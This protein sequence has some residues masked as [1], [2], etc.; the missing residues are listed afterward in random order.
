VAIL[1]DERDVVDAPLRRQWEASDF[2]IIDDQQ[3]RQALDHFLRRRG[4]VMRME[5]KCRGRLID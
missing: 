2:I 4:V 5:P 3:A 1:D